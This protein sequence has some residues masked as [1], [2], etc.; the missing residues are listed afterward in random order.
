MNLRHLILAYCVTWLLQLG[1]LAIV[2][3]GWWKL[4][5]KTGGAPAPPSA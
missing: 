3:V 5:R 2:L 1:Y 4:R